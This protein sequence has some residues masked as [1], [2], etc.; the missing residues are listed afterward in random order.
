MG[1]NI[2]KKAFEPVPR[3]L[4]AETL[5]RLEEARREWR[6]RLRPYTDRIR[7]AA[8]LTEEDYRIYINT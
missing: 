6:E 3:E 4:D 2:E 7:A 5:A 8:R 1:N